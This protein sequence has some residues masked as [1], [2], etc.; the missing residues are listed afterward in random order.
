MKC[1]SVEEVFLHKFPEYVG[2]I[3][4]HAAQ[5]ME[6]L[7]PGITDALDLESD[8]GLGLQPNPQ[9]HNFELDPHGFANQ[10]VMDLFDEFPTT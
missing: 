4:V 9:G 2:Q 7:P 5:D 3:S 1:W 10:C 6:N 8:F